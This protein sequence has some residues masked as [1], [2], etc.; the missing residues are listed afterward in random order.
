MLRQLVV[1]TFPGAEPIPRILHQTFRTRDLKPELAASVG[2]MRRRNPDWDYRFYDDADVRAY[3]LQHYGPEFLVYFD[4]LNPKYAAAKADL[5]RY[6]LMYREGGVYLDIKS[7]ASRPLGEVIAPS[8]RFLLSQWRTGPESRFSKWGV[9]SELKAFE[10]GEFQ[11][12]FIVAAPGHPF[13]KATIEAVLRNIRGYNALLHSIGKP[14]VLRTTG[15]IAYTR[16]IAPLR[17]SHPCRLVDSSSDLGFQYSIYPGQDHQAAL[18]AHYSETAEALVGA[19]A[20]TAAQA[21]LRRPL[22]KLRRVLESRRRAKAAFAGGVRTSGH[23]GDFALGA[24]FLESAGLTAKD[25]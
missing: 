17:A 2:A 15:P 23:E 1:P 7:H 11:Q 8:D 16:A 9:H 6:L 12:W 24:D 3:V 19:G 10:G 20:A 25:A 14:A 5:F 18:G 21:A 22:R 4:A 13:L